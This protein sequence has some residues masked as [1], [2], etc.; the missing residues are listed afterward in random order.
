MVDSAEDSAEDSAAA[1]DQAQALLALTADIVAAHASNNA[2]AVSDMPVVIA[3]VHA[4]LAQL[5]HK[6]AS[7][8]DKA[9]GTPAVSVRA[10]VKHDGIT[11]LDCGSRYQM[12]KR[13]LNSSHQLTPE[14]YRDRWNLPASYPMVA[15]DYANKRRQLAVKVGLGRKPAKAG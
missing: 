15:F 13:H 7:V 10:S 9:P 5:G 8:A 11:C 12:L 2:V 3:S 6:S 14:E 4:A 1:N